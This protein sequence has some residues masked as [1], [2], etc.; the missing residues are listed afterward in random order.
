MRQSNVN[1][2]AAS[3]RNLFSSPCWPSSSPACARYCPPSSNYRKRYLSLTT[4]G[5]GRQTT[6]SFP[7]ALHLYL[8]HFVPKVFFLLSKPDPANSTGSQPGGEKKQTRD[9]TSIVWPCAQVTRRRCHTVPV[10][11]MLLG[12]VHQI[13]WPVASPP[14]FAY[15]KMRILNVYWRFSTW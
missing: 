5:C 11:L 8:S 6:L 14:Y 2:L 12:I 10:A 9:V 15:T 1:S 3:L 4:I 13:L 7:V